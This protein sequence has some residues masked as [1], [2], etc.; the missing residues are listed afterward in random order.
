MNDFKILKKPLPDLSDQ[1]IPGRKYI[2]NY[3]FFFFLLLNNIGRYFQ[4]V[5]KESVNVDIQIQTTF[6]KFFTIFLISI[7]ET[8]L[9]QKTFLI[10]FFK[11]F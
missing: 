7:V 8:K 6:H 10:F 11:V 5:C 3:Q 9:F 4:K 2:H 1:D